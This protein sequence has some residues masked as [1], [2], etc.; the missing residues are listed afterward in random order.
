MELLEAFDRALAEFDGRVHQVENRRWEAGTPCTDWTVR[1]LVNHLTAEHLWA[2]SLLSGAALDEVGD[3]FEGDVLGDD[4]VRSW[5]RAAAESRLAF[6]RPGALDGQVNTSG[7]VIPAEEYGW[8]M[9]MDL[10]VHAW[11]LARGIGAD[12]VMD[13]DL[14]Q[15]VYDRFAPQASHWQG[16]G[17]FEAPVEVPESADAQD[18]LVA[19]F[20]RRP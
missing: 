12:D 11:D 19:L 7:G 8:Q 10:T 5:E 14:V 9:T 3:R 15:G 13:K 4:P 17:I 1:D 6:H 18:R 2:P 16:L 20:G